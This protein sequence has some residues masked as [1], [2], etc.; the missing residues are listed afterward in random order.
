MTEREK[1]LLKE[2]KEMKRHLAREKENA[3]LAMHL[4]LSSQPFG[5][6]MPDGRIGLVNRGFELLTGYTREELSRLDW[7]RSLTPPEYFE[8]E[9][10]Y[11]DELGETGKTVRY[12]K[13]IIRK[14]GTR[15]PV[16][17]VVNVMKDSDGEPDYFF[18]FITD[19][20][21]R[22]KDEYKLHQLIRKLRAMQDSSLLMVQATN[23][24]KFLQDVCE[25]IVEDCGYLMAWI[26]YKQL[27]S[28]KTVK[29]VAYAGFEENYLSTVQI[30]WGN[31]EKGLGP[32]GTTIRTGKTSLSNIKTDPNFKLWRKEAL[33]RGYSSMI[34]LPLFMDEEVFGALTIYSKDP[35][36]FSDDEQHLLSKLA[37]DLSYGIKAIRL[38]FALQQSKENL[39]VKVRQRT[40]LL[41][42]TIDNLAAEKQR[43][44]DVL[45][46]VPAYVALITPDHEI[47]FKNNNFT[48]YFGELN[49][50]KCYEI[51]FGRN[52]VCYNCKMSKVI[53]KGVPSH[54]E[55]I[56]RN[57]R[58]YQISDFVFNDSDDT[59]MMLEIGT[60]ITDKRNMEKMMI[61]KILE[62]EELD[63]RR[64][65]SDLHD[66]LG[67]TLSAIKL[68]LSLLGTAKNSQ[69]RDKLLDICYQLLLEGIDK[70]RTVANNIMPNLIESYGLDT[71]VQSFIRKMEIPKKLVF[72]FHSNIQGYRFEKEAE[73]H[74]Y[75]IITELVTNT[76]KHSRA[77]E[78]SLD[79]MLT[80]QDLRIEY[81]DNGI[82]Y[83]VIKTENLSGGSGIQNIKNR[84]NLMHG[85]IEFEKK[86]GKTRV[87]ITKPL[88]KRISPKP[89]TTVGKSK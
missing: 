41:K 33:K 10:C 82:G 27:D 70:M 83:D 76:I 13:E 54:W 74:L 24:N 36:P 89:A 7:I 26:G 61:S 73:L 59:S 84:V 65:A 9:K 62:T 49:N 78:V 17:L 88:S 63:R 85:T 40:S 35:D 79:I 5:I 31:T 29:P 21:G 86:A 87:K 66:D 15:V 75:R 71:A 23:E 19:I 50:Q 2:N 81:Y 28:G 69:E 16:E 32:A 46:M 43:F 57:D 22:K 64:F 38:N 14:D 51:F 30:S 44:Q 12:E 60:D 47:T 45:N 20:T 18:S 56:C 37:H 39:E 80:D 55:A 58:I 48:K 25:I 1:Q 52:E 34:A 11:L 4:D 67:P 72:K 3:M 77:K 42:K 6:G 8:L 68:Q 53:S